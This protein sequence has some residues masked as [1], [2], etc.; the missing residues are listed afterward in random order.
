MD[1]LKNLKQNLDK[2]KEY[3]F[4]NEL[5]NNLEQLVNI[6]NINKLPKIEKSNISLSD[7]LNIYLDKLSNNKLIIFVFD[8]EFQHL[9][10]DNKGDHVERQILEFGGMIFLKINDKWIYHCKLHFNLPQINDNNLAIIAGKYASVTDYT[11][12]KMKT[13]FDSNKTLY[14]NPNNLLL[15][16]RRGA[17]YSPLTPFNKDKINTRDFNTVETMLS[18]EVY[19]NVNIPTNIIKYNKHFDK[20]WELYNNDTLVKNRLVSN[21]DWIPNLKYILKN[22]MKIYKGKEDIKALKILFDNNIQQNDTGYDILNDTKDSKVNI[23]YF[24][25][26]NYNEDLKT[27]Y[28]TDAAKLENSFKYL[29]QDIALTNIIKDINNINPDINKAH[30]PITD[31]TFTLFIAVGILIKDIQFEQINY[32]SC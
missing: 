21:Y 7:N 12:N 20:M 29:M 11:A 6:L 13:E 4:K 9:N 10:K 24:D 3:S 5:C 26:G 1:F 27:K 17:K 2:L 25:I 22:S 18:K 15:G 32:T 30:N 19:K 31:S 16:C 28:D 23:S 14:I 8:C